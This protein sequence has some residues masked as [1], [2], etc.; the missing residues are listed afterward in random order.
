MNN[1]LPVLQRLRNA[2]KSYVGGAEGSWRGPFYGQGEL[3]SWFMMNPIEEGWQRN[4]HLPMSGASHVP[5]VYACVMAQA[6]A[7]A[8]CYATHRKIDDKGAHVDQVNS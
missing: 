5:I 8:L 7:V 4:L 3:G 2:F 1:K 6:R